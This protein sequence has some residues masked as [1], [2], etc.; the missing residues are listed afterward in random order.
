MEGP[1]PFLTA[2]GLVLLLELGDKTQLVTVSL[3]S[4]HPWRPVFLGAT[5]GLLLA[6]AIGVVV[7]ALLASALTAWLVAVKVGGGILFIALG[8][9]TYVRREV[10]KEVPKGRGV[11]GTAFTLNF[12][13]EIG[14]K[15]QIAVI[16]LVASTAAPVSV[17]AGAGLALTMLV[18]VSIVLGVGLARILKKEWIPRVTSALFIVAGVLLIAEAVLGG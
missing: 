10:E 17:F 16:V 14:D 6:T 15:S 3:A 4:R 12:V 5:A 7:G 13:A 2:L 9:W 18:G 1:L 11:F 8:V